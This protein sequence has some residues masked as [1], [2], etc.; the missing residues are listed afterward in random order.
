MSEDVP[1]LQFPDLDEYDDRVQAT[2]RFR[3][4]MDL[5]A[6]RNRGLAARDRIKR[7]DSIAGYRKDEM[8]SCA[9]VTVTNPPPRTHN[10]MDMMESD[11]FRLPRSK[12]H[13]HKAADRQLPCS[14]LVARSV[15]RSEF[16]AN[17]DAMDAYWKEWRN[18]E[19]KQTW[20][21]ETLSE[22]AA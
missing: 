14:L 20:R 12:R 11:D 16:I 2:D 21:M 9:M 1:D 17:K 7:D 13:R 15:P 19:K 18:L 6:I 8:A 4:E 10:S 3:E 5:A 22:W